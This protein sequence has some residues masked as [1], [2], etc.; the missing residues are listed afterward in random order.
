MGGPP[1]RAEPAWH[2][3]AAGQMHGYREPDAGAPISPGFI[4]AALKVGDTSN[5]VVRGATFF[6]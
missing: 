2:T 1:V 5:P 6:Q 3:D 4:L